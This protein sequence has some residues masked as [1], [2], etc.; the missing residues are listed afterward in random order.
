MP[1]P[2]FGALPGE[3]DRVGGVRP[4]HQEARARDDAAVVRL[5]DAAVDLVGQAEIVGVD[6]DQALSHVGIGNLE[7]G[8]RLAGREQAAHASQSRSEEYPSR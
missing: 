3:P 6:D 7:G 4:V 8:V 2:R 1:R 5:E